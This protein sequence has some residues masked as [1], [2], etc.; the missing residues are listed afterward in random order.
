MKAIT[1]L[2]TRDIG[3]CRL[4]DG[5]VALYAET[6]NETY[7]YP[8]EKWSDPYLLELTQYLI[9]KYGEATSPYLAFLKKQQIDIQESFFDEDGKLLREKVIVAV[10]SYILQGLD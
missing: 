1:K 2:R 4:E 10:D 5:T 7:F 6:G 3:L 9:L 8:M